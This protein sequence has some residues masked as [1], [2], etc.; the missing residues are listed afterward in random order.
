[1]WRAEEGFRDQE[2]E[3]GMG[4]IPHP[5]VENHLTETIQVPVSNFNFQ[6]KFD[7]HVKN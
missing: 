4:E 6:N 3:Y 1:M 7:I 2:Q 5:S